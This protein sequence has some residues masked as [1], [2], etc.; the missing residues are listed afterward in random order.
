MLG[1][2]SRFAKKIATSGVG[3]TVLGATA[4]LIGGPAAGIAVN[5]AIGMLGEKK[6]GEMASKVVSDGTV[7][8]DKV[9]GTLEKSG[10]VADQSGIDDVVNGLKFSAMGIGSKSI[11]VTKGSLI[12]AGGSNGASTTGTLW[13]K[14]KVFFYNIKSWLFANWKKALL[15]GV[16]PVVVM[17]GV[18]YLFVKKTKYRR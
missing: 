8:V 5:K 11:S 13:D 9:I 16:L 15:Y 3:R 4:T 12:A 14:V 1:G 2:V 17:V 10:I 18:Y 7:K 6:I